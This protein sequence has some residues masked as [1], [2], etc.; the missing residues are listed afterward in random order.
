MRRPV[1]LVLLVVGMIVS[2]VLPAGGDAAQHSQHVPLHPIGDAPLRDGFVENI[3]TQGPQVYAHEIYVL[4][5]A[6]PDAMFDAHLT[7]YP[8][9][10]TCAGSPEAVLPTTSLATNRAGNGQARATIA[11]EDVAGFPRG[12][13]G[14]VW[15]VTDGT[16][17]Y[18]SDCTPV[19]LD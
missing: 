17:T 14:V 6:A 18:E 10:P 9:D 12:T 2:L 15:T 8:F 13:H 1:I 3:H 19:T 4:N 11:P 5:G 7:P 16:H